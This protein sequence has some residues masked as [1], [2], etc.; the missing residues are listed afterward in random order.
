[1]LEYL[2]A[3]LPIVSTN[4]GTRGLKLEDR[5]DVIISDLESFH[6][7]IHEILQNESLRLTLQRIAEEGHVSMTGRILQLV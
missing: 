6:M 2:S 4:I 3:P 1:M 5:K 7:S